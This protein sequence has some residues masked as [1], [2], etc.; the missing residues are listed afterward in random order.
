[1]SV[2]ITKRIW[3]GVPKYISQQITG[4]ND[5]VPVNSNS[6]LGVVPTEGVQEYYW[7]L[8]ENYTSCG[9]TTNSSGLTYC[10]QGTIKP[11]FPNG[12]TTSYTST[13]K[14]ANVIWGNCPGTYFVQC[15]YKNECGLTPINH[16][17]VNVFSPTG[18]G[19]SDPCAGRLSMSPN[20]INKYSTN[21]EFTANITY[22]VDP[23]DNPT[24]NYRTNEVKIYDFY[25]NLVYS[26]NF[27]TD[28]MQIRNVNL[29]KGNYALN[30]FT[31]KGYSLREIIVVE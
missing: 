9:C 17:Y 22:P 5:N 31:Y 26:Q 25:G 28:E 23:C 15:Y 21:G 30:V 13:S 20:P 4:G 24:G 8:S 14:N 19:G 6:N 27:D 16:K 1:V 3:V 11:K 12:S 2:P 7:T 29:Q 18:G 10:P